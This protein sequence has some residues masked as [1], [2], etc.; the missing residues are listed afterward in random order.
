MCA[1]SSVV[2]TRRASSSEY[3][4]FATIRSNSSPPVSRSITRYSVQ[5]VSITRCSL[6]MF[7]WSAIVSTSISVLSMCIWLAPGFLMTLTAT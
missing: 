6:T 7:G 2:V 3:E 4:P 1:S 5:C